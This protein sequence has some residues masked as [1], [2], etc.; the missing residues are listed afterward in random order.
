MT[1]QSDQDQ[2][3]GAGTAPSVNGFEA[4]KWKPGQ[5]GNPG[6]RPAGYLPFAPMLRRALLKA[7]RRNRTQ[8]EK[9]AEKVVAMAAQGDMD[10]VRWLADRVDGKVAQSISVDSQQTVHVVPWLP[11]VQNAAQELGLI[12]AKREE[13]EVDGERGE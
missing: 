1:S 6:G 10:A 7:D 4:R 5:T 11:A 9:I 2:P 3:P 12:E 13:V 8:M